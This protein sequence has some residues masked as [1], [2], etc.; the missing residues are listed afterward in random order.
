MQSLDHAYNSENEWKTGNR[1]WKLETE[2][3][4]EKEMQPLNCSSPCKSCV[5]LAF[6]SSHPQAASSFDYT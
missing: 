5:V 6:I 2:L 4:A 1:K 3:E